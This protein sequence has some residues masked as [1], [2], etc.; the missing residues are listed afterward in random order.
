M[1]THSSVYA[2][3]SYGQKSRVGYSPG[4]TK[5][6]TRLSTPTHTHIQLM[7]LFVIWCLPPFKLLNIDQNSSSFTIGFALLVN[8][9]S[10]RALEKKHKGLK[11]LNSP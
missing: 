4:V 11:A 2:G 8:I 9:V 3:K 5:S 7:V 6:R 1:A 10:N